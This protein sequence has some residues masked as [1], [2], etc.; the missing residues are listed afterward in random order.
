MQVYSLREGY[1]MHTE[2]WRDYILETGR[3]KN[4]DKDEHEAGFMEL[5]FKDR[6][7]MCI[8]QDFIQRQVS[9][10]DVSMQSELVF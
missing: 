5:C 9:N 6:A 2:I 3:Q 4:A 7:W 8:A 1:E 10:L